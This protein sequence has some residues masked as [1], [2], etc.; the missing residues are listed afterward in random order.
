MVSECGKDNTRTIN[1][2]IRQETI[3]GVMHYDGAEYFV[4]FVP[5]GCS[6][7]NWFNQCRIFGELVVD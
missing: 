2:S 7:I 3:L 6:Y 1:Q 5:V 4:I